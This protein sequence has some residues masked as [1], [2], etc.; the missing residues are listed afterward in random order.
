MSDTSRGIAGKGAAS[1]ETA[2]ARAT[3]IGAATMM[4]GWAVWGLTSVFAG[5]QLPVAAVTPA[6]FVL[7]AATA[8]VLVLG[9]LCWNVG[10]LRGKPTTLSTLSYLTPVCSV[11]SSAII[12]GLSLAPTFWAG[13]AMVGA[14]SLISFASTRRQKGV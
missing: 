9:Y 3:V 8:L 6:S 11:A 14:G 10:I 5:P 13:L 4:S 1:G 12:L 2:A 7:P